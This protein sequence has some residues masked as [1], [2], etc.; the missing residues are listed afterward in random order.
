MSFDVSGD[1]YDRFMGRYSLPLAPA[2]ADFAGVE[3]GQRAVDVGCGTGVLTEELARRLGAD[4][5]AGADPSPML[6][7]AAERVPGADLRQASA[8]QLPW[9]DDSF[10]AALAQLVVHFMDDPARGA[11]EMGRVT[12]PGGVVAACTWDFAGGG[13]VLLGTFWES[14]RALDPGADSETSPLGDRG[15]LDALWRESGLQQVETE[16]LEVSSEYEDF[17]E[18]WSS[19]SRGVGPAGQ[20]L[21]T[22]PPERQDAIRAE[23]FSRIGEPPGSFTLPA[24]AWAARGRVPG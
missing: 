23:Y 21:L 7:A 11:A 5:V 3:A 17:D 16:A 22:Q 6:Q 18:L 15:R 1:A 12:R 19:F 24:R 8:E 9:A 20:Y 10:D 2:F 4:H 14:V 13:M